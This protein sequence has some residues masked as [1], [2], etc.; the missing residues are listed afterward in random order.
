MKQK[1]RI[2]VSQHWGIQETDLI[3]YIEV[4]A[5]LEIFVLTMIGYI[6][7]NVKNKFLIQIIIVY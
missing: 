7:Q 5:F 3:S 2:E 4:L 6:I 1:E